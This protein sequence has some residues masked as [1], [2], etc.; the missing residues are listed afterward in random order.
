MN[1]ERL[2]IRIS[3]EL[4]TKLN[5]LSENSKRKASD[6]LRLLI[7]LADKKKIKL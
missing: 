4:L 3:K 5:K 1:T 2:E 7:E 6:Y